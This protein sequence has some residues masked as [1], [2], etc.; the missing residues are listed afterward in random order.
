LQLVSL[1]N[2]VSEDGLQRQRCSIGLNNEEEEIKICSV[3]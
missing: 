2:T 3:K 1:E